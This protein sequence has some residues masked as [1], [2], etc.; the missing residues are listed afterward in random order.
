MSVLVL[1]LGLA[2]FLG[3]HS[4]R[5]FADDWRNAQVGRI[6]LGRYKGL[7]SMPS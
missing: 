6:G 1:V 5:I 3:L 7:Y 2:I 4:I